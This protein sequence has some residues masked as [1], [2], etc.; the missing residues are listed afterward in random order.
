MIYVGIAKK[1]RSNWH[2]LGRFQ[3]SDNNSSDS[4]F[5]YQ[6]KVFTVGM[7]KPF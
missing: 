7:L 6:R 2:I 4:Q 1:F 5:S 3:Y